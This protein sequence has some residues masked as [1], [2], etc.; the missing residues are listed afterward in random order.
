MNQYDLIYLN[1]H[2]K[3]VDITKVSF[4]G[5]IGCVSRTNL[6]ICFIPSIQLVPAGIWYLSM[7]TSSLTAMRIVAGT[8]GYILQV[9]NV[10]TPSMPDMG[11]MTKGHYDYDFNGFKIRITIMAYFVMSVSTISFN[12]NF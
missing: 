3:S 8:G 5:G 2:V 11:Q 12:Y 6:I 10:V 7:N 4:T 1:T 9:S